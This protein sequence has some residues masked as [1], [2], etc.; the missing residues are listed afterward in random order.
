MRIVKLIVRAVAELKAIGIDKRVRGLD[1]RLDVEEARDVE[2]PTDLARETQ[3]HV[4]H[5]T[6]LAAV[7]RHVGLGGGKTTHHVHELA[8]LTHPQA[9]GRKTI[10]V[11]VGIAAPVVGFAARIAQRCAEADR[12]V[13]G[14]RIDARLD[15]VE[16]VF[17]A[18]GAR[19]AT[20][21]IACPD[22]R[23][24]LRRADVTETLS[25]VVHKDPVDRKRRSGG[26]LKR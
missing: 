2:A 12:A 21:V 19:E 17:K 10:E 9:V 26:E 3:R 15:R 7:N 14:H 18:S 24:T 13:V 20:A 6:L 25:H 8:G 1:L 5:R 23:L 16:V 22:A 4:V 11:H